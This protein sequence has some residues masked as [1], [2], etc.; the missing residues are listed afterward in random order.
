MDTVDQGQGAVC[1][2]CHG[3]G[4]ITIYAAEGAFIEGESTEV[5]PTVEKPKTCPTCN[6]TGRVPELPTHEGAP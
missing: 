5:Q 1:Q 3:T 4:T 6:G 2:E